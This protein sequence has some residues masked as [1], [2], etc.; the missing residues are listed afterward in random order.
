MLQQFG[1]PVTI[2]DGAA[3][4]WGHS[5]EDILA[6]FSD[7][8][9]QAKLVPDEEHFIDKVACKATIGWDE[10]KHSKLEKVSLTARG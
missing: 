1:M 9:Y 10:L 7:A 6:V 2:Y 8:K 3:E 4:F 5:I